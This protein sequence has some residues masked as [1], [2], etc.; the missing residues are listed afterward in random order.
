MALKHA[1]IRR[2][3]INSIEQSINSGH[4]IQQQPL[5]L[6]FAL[7]APVMSW[8]RSSKAVSVQLPLQD[9]HL[10]L[11]NPIVTRRLRI[12]P[13]PAAANTSLTLVLGSLE[14]HWGKDHR[15]M[16]DYAGI[17]S[18]ISSRPSKS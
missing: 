7:R 8:T 18:P 10:R 4:K 6:M 17:M 2:T 13:Q 3:L 11:K 1:P 9:R 15:L 5:A 14:R 16:S 12:P